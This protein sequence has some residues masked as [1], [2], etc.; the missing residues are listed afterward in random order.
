MEQ[1]DGEWGEGSGNG[2]WSVKNKLTKKKRILFNKKK[3]LLLTLRCH[4]VAA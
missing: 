1:S 4:L 2:I 3:M